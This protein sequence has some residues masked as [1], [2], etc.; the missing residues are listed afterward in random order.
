M[1]PLQVGKSHGK[2]APK[3][4]QR[5]IPLC[6][7]VG[8]ASLHLNRCSAADASLDIPSPEIIRFFSPG[9]Y[10]QRWYL[11]QLRQE[12]L[13]Y[14]ATVGAAATAPFICPL[15][16]ARAKLHHAAVMCLHLVTTAPRG[17]DSQT[18]LRD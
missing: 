3:F 11:M 6:S 7:F 1:R 5:I 12:G 4:P 10:H 16:S 8:W 2:T 14:P 15:P 18:G 9:G 13:N 17:A